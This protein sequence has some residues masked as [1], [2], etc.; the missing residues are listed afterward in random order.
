MK[1][2]L[3]FAGTLLFL[4]ACAHP[5]KAYTGP[6]RPTSEVAIVR[7]ESEG[8]VVDQIFNSLLG[9]NNDRRV[10]IRFVNDHEMKYSWVEIAPGACSLGLSY[11]DEPNIRSKGYIGL[12]FSAQAGHTYIIGG[13]KKNDWTWNASVIDLAEKTVVAQ[14][15]GELYVP[16]EFK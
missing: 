5:Y 14:G 4:T 10:S 2:T 8:Q 13:F 15:S 16:G 1:I 7:T 6:R 11:A 12:S 3:L 9:I